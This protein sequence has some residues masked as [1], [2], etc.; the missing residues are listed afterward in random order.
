MCSIIIPPWKKT[1]E[2]LIHTAEFVKTPSILDFILYYSDI[3]TQQSAWSP[4][5]K[6]RTQIIFHFLQKKRPLDV[7]P[8]NILDT[9]GQTDTNTPSL[10]CCKTLQ[11]HNYAAVWCRRSTFLSST[12]N[13]ILW[14][15][16]CLVINVEKPIIRTLFLFSF[17]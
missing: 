6:H 4:H 12:H 7:K 5:W 9:A 11:A 2:L 16:V 15:S 14:K 13:L 3:D 1:N 17:F 10:L 8:F